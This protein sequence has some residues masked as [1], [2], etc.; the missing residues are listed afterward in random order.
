M[1]N[2]LNPVTRPKAE[3][4]HLTTRTE[5]LASDVYERCEGV[6]TLPAFNAKSAAPAASSVKRTANSQHANSNGSL[7]KK[8][9]LLKHL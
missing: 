2:I 4:K 8:S 6:K 9:S 5:K 1:D 3:S 7:L